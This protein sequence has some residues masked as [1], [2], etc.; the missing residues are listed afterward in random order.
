VSGDP[1]YLTVLFGSSQ[2]AGLRLLIPS[3]G[4]SRKEFVK[5]VGCE[6]RESGLMERRLLSLRDNEI[7]LKRRPIFLAKCSQ[8]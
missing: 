6:K 5:I 7:C 3:S 8:I 4:T 2:E 1:M